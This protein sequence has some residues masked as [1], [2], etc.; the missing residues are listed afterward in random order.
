[1]EDGDS[2]LNEHYL[3]TLPWHVVTH[4]P[5]MFCVLFSDSFC[6]FIQ[7]Y[8]S[9]YMNPS[10]VAILGRRMSQRAT[11]ITHYT[12]RDDLLSTFLP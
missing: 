6:V 10:A 2:I 1:M 4:M 7:Y 3:D 8:S 11:A 12:M 5:C 9:G